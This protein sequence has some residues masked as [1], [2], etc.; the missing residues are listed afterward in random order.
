[1]FSFGVGGLIADTIGWEYIFYVLGGMG[2]LWAVAWILIIHETPAKNPRMSKAEL[3]YL[4]ATTESSFDEDSNG[5]SDKFP[6]LKAIATSVPFIALVVTHFA[7]DWGFY[8]LG[9]GI[10]QYLNDVHGLSL[11]E[12]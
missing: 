12:V 5:S 8:V 2:M 1:M 3:E 6:P 10:P 11:D 7:N 9:T 4:A